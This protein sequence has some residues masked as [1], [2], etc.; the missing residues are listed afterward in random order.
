MNK[1]YK[2]VYH[3]FEFI[4]IFKIKGKQKQMNLRTCII[5]VLLEFFER[6][7]FFFVEKLNIL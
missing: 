3:D 4:P 1:I 6:K 7:Y 2:I 5:V